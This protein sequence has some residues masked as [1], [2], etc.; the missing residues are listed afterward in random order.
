MVCHQQAS[1]VLA[2]DDGLRR[3]LLREAKTLAECQLKAAGRL[4][5]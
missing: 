3:A 5:F 1:E 2:L 4:V